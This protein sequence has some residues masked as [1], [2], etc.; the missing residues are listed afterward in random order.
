MPRRTYADVP[1]PRYDE[2]A[3]VAAAG[4]RHVDGTEGGLW[5]LPICRVRR[6]VAG[7]N[8][9]VI[10][11]AGRDFYDYV[12]ALDQ[13]DIEAILT[14]ARKSD[15]ISGVDC[16]ILDQIV[17]AD[18][19][20]ASGM[21]SRSCR[22][23]LI[24]APPDGHLSGTLRRHQSLGRHVRSAQRQIGPVTETIHDTSAIRELLPSL[25]RLHVERWAF[26]NVESAFLEP[27]RIR[28]Y[29]AAA[30]RAMVTRVMA[31]DQILAIHY[32]LVFGGTLLWHTP[33]I[34]VAFLDFS[35]LEILLMSVAE[36]CDQNGIRTID[37]GLGD[38]SYK[39]RFSTDNRK[40]SEL[41]F[42]LS[43]KG[44]LI[45]AART[46]VDADAWR[47]HCDRVMGVARQAR[48]KVMQK[49]NRVR[50]FHSAVGAQPAMPMDCY[51]EI[52]TWCELVP[53]LR[54][55]TIEIK[56]YQYDRIRSGQR[57][58]CVM[59]DDEIVCYGW[60]SMKNE[61]F[62][63]GETGESIPA[64]TSVLYDFVTPERHRNR[65]NYT[66]LLQAIAA[67]RQNESLCIFALVNNRASLA[68]IQRA[69]YV[70]RGR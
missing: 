63:V 67:A 27:L 36:S 5:P 12:A 41:I 29:E 47:R 19:L 54:H 15:E 65:G 51:R 26:E 3:N 58:V 39:A 30:E 46:R 18:G 14:A 7:F 49:L 53:L 20:S 50:F 21:A 23:H 59:Q 31:G 38:E 40:V 25:G 61:P 2:L 60:V 62:V 37:L 28:Q 16:V 10:E 69:G 13:N 22:T 55:S 34:N 57:F 17:N 48:V 33:V 6:Q 52:S 70:E 4:G 9:N 8:A 44:R 32:G 42:P 35:P 24:V 45:A 68:G 43:S 56:R 11:V 1:V 64:G 66:R